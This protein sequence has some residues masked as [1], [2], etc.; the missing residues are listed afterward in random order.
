MNLSKEFE[1]RENQ[2]IKLMKPLYGLCDAGDYWNDMMTK[3]VKKDIKVT[4]STQD[5]SL[6]YKKTQRKVNLTFWDICG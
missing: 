3:N 1:L 6:F 5:I 4:P 2:I